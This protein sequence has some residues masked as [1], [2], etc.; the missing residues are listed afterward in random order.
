MKIFSIK[1][2]EFY[3]KFYN[4][5]EDYIVYVFHSINSNLLQDEDGF[6]HHCF[7]GD[8]LALIVIINKVFFKI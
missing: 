5:L 8:E 6:Y 2:E 1:N 7:D 4:K 3:N